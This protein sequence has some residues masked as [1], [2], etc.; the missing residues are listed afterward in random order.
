MTQAIES[1]LAAR[2][3]PSATLCSNVSVAT[4]SHSRSGE[5]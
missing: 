1:A 2:T 4:K 5:R 3:S